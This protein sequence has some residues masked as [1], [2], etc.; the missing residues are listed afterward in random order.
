MDLHTECRVLNTNVFQINLVKL[1]FRATL[2]VRL[3]SMASCLFQNYR[4]QN[5]VV[6]VSRIDLVVIKIYSI[7]ATINSIVCKINL[8]K[9][10]TRCQNNDHLHFTSFDRVNPSTRPW[11]HPL[12]MRSNA[13]SAHLVAVRPFAV[14]F[15]FCFVFT[16]WNN[17]HCHQLGLAYG[18]ETWAY[19]M[20]KLLSATVVLLLLLD[21]NLLPQ[22]GI[23]HYWQLHD[24]DGTLL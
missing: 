3:G 8:V 15:C 4:F 10:P 12:G 22:A 5:C 21:T 11:P 20:N 17:G 19:P 1:S 7:Y 9:K 18:R 14:F 24:N 23:S 13:V 6:C 16:F 2:K